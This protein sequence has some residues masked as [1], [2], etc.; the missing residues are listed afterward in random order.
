M[1]EKSI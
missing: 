1:S